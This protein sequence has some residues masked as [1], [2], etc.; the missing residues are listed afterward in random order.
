MKTYV[1]IVMFVTIFVT[2]IINT[3]LHSVTVFAWGDSTYEE[4]GVAGATRTLYTQEQIDNGALDDGKIT[5]NSITDASIG[6]EIDFTSAQKNAPDG[7][8]VDSHGIWEGGNITV[9]DGK[10]YVVRLYVHNN[11]PLA[12]KG[13]AKNTKVA[14]S[15]IGQ[16][17][18]NKDGKQEVE[19][20]GFIKSDNST[21]KEY[22]DYVRFNSSTSFHL[23]YVYGSAMIYN[24]GA[25]GTTDPITSEQAA[26]MSVDEMNT[27]EVTGRPL[28]D[29]IV[30]KAGSNDGTLIGFDA[31]DGNVPGCYAYSSYITIRVKAVFDNN[32]TVKAAVRLA[33]EKK[34]SKCIDAKVG[35]KIELQIEYTNTSSER[36]DGVALRDILPA[37][38]HYIEGSTKI[39]NARYPNGNNIRENYLITDGLKIGNY[40]PD[41]N[42]YLIFTAE[43]VDDDLSEGLNTIENIVSGGMKNTIIEDS[44]KINIQNNKKFNIIIIG[45]VAVAIICLIIIIVCRIAKQ[46]KNHKL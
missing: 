30:L 18:T 3:F 39:K 4:T 44:V 43:V 15:G 25:V 2:L 32:F 17:K 38:L 1:R 46:N 45:H 31:L 11:S 7:L 6:N 12:T 13:V 21:P 34:W 35:D 42:A 9:E 37:N 27:H 20:N 40:N 22:W 14:I 29:D 26:S 5:F 41:A 28:S 8:S 16:S 24:R 33:G 19:V 23:D 10:E 36:Q